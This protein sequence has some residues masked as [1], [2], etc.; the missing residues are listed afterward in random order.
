MIGRLQDQVRLNVIGVVLGDHVVDGRRDQHVTF[1]CQQFTVGDLAAAVESRYTAGLLLVLL[2]PGDTQACGVVQTAVD[3]AHGD[4]AATAVMDQPGGPGADVPEALHH[5]LGPIG[6]Q[7]QIDR[8][9]LQQI[10]HAPAGGRLP[11]QR[12]AHLHRFSGDDGRSVAV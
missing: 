2:Q 6:V 3:A 9:F 12:T 1:Q 5:N 11:A 8:N 10:G 7:A 4:H